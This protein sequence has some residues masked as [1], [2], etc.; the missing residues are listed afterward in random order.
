VTVNSAAA[1]K[2]MAYWQKL[3]QA[4]LVSVDPDFTDAWYQGLASGK[5]ASWLTPAWGP[6]FLQGTAKGTAG[7]WRAVELPQFTAGAHDSADAGGSS[8]AV[9]KTT[10]NP[11]AAYELTKWI[12]N[13]KS[14]TLEFATK[15]SLFPTAKNVL[16]DPAFVEQKSPFFGGQQV[17]KLYAEIA[18]NVGSEVQHLPY[19]D[20]VDSSFNDTLG[21]AIATKGDLS[22]GLDA[23]QEALVTYGKQQGFTVK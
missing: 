2:V 18:N 7:K 23:W 3:I 13:D 17:N 14:S 6:L 11:I 10:K 19:M 22:A 12:N 16:T 21:K 4:N 9:L 5:Y 1:K 15:Q 8:N 20:Y